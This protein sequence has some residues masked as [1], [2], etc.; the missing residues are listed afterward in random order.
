MPSMQTRKNGS[1]L[2]VY[3]CNNLLYATSIVYFRI[4]KHKE[5]T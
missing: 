5:S 4:R 3:M 1:G 2:L